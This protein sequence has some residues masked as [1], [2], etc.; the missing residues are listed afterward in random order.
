MCLNNKEGQF[1]SKLLG[2]FN[3][4]DVLQYIETLHKKELDDKADFEKRLDELSIDKEQITTELFEKN[5]LVDDL[6]NMLFDSNKKNEDFLQNMQDLQE[7]LSRYR[8]ILK[9]KDHELNITKEKNKQLSLKMET[10][11]YKSNRY[12]E[13]NEKIGEAVTE[14]HRQAESIINNAHNEAR[15]IMQQAK[16][17][18]TDVSNRALFFKE[19][20]SN[21]RKQIDRFTMDISQYIDCLD[22]EITKTIKALNYNDKDLSDNI[23]TLVGQQSTKQRK[24]FEKIRKTEKMVSSNLRS[25]EDT[26]IIDID[27]NYSFNN[28]FGLADDDFFKFVVE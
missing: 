21:L 14:A 24:H 1:K 6:Q 11:I 4:K 23:A 9:Q 20:I 26:N 15:I 13:L 17:T 19:E 12:D 2:G 25:L 16:N 10:Y 3:R 22:K 27:Q 5:E 28:D 18:M 7:E 8:I